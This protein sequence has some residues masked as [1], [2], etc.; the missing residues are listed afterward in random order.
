MT[1]AT[2]FEYKE[3]Q[4]L[5]CRY[6]HPP[7][8]RHFTTPPWII[9]TLQQLPLTK[10]AT[11][12]TSNFITLNFCSNPLLSIPPLNLLPHCPLYSFHAHPGAVISTAPSGCMQY[13]RSPSAVIKS[14][15][16]GPRIESRSRYLSN[17]RYTACVRVEENFCAIKWE[18]DTPNSFMFGAPF[19][20]NMTELGGAIGGLCSADDFVGIDQ[21]SADGVGPGED[22]FCGNRLLDSNVVISRSKPFQLK[23]R[24]NADQ[25]LNAANSQQGFSLRYVQL[26]CVI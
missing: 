22:R 2:G 17:L 14:F 18:T 25:T 24:S 7:F 21:G 12:C 10:K 15:N 4:S 6:H 9:I 23:V 20:G 8:H 5:P 13:Y 16:Y 11:F 3:C 19:E 1:P 26:P